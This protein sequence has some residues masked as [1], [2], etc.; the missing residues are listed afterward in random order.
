MQTATVVDETT[1]ESSA[2][3]GVRSEEEEGY[4][5]AAS[6]VRALIYMVSAV[7]VVMAFVLL[8]SSNTPAVHSACGHA[9]WEFLLVRTIFM[10]LELLQIGFRQLLR[11]ATVNDDAPKS[12]EEEE[13]NGGALLQHH[14]HHADEED[15]SGTWYGDLLH[16]AYNFAFAVYATFVVPM[17]LVDHAPC[18]TNALVLASFTGTYT[19]A[20]FA[21]I[22]FVVDWMQ[23]IVRGLTL[24]VRAHGHHHASSSG[25]EVTVDT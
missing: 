9:L 24:L 23:V 4:A 20:S 18:C 25:A 17:A 12:G 8:Q 7:G 22:F 6:V 11:I 5:I 1:I 21:W 2:P 16:L 19:L 13:E 3:Q 10:L 15:D 14:Q